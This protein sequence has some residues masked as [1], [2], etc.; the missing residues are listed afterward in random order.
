MLVGTVFGVVVIPV[1]FVIL[2]GLQERL[3][4]GGPA[5]KETKVTQ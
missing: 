5:A 1:L 2:Q 4:G 3:R